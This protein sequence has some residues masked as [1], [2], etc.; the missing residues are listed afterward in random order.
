MAKGP[1]GGDG[2]SSGPRRTDDL[3]RCERMAACR[4]EQLVEQ[5]VHTGS[6]RRSKEDAIPGDVE[7]QLNGSQAIGILK[8]SIIIHHWIKNAQLGGSVG[9][10]PRRRVP[11]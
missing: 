1:G 8:W 9:C 7:P 5:A 10:P 2:E 3:L 6:R 4:E 11:K